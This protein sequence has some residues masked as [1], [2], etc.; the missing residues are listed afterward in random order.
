[1]SSRP[2][3]VLSLLLWLLPLAACA[4]SDA[5]FARNMAQIG[6]P[7]LADEAGSGNDLFHRLG[8]EPTNAR[9]HFENGRYLA[10]RG[11][12]GDLEMAR[13]AFA[14]ASRLA[15]DWWLPEIALAATEYRLGRYHLA[16]S[17]FIEAVERRGECGTL[18]YGFALAA[19]RA[20]YFGLAVNA[21]AAAKQAGPPIGRAEQRAAEFLSLA[22]ADGPDARPAAPLRERLRAPAPAEPST[23]SHNVA[24]DA[25]V[26]R[27]TR[28]SSSSN[29]INLLEALQLQFGATLVNLDYSS[30]SRQDPVK[31]VQRSLEVS[32]PTVTYA[33]N[34]A[35]ESRTTFSIEATPSVVAVA[36]QT[37]RFFEGANVLI[38]P[39]GDD[40]SPV[41]RD[42]GI[43]LQVTPS[44]IAE[45][46]V[47]LSASMELSTLAAQAV[48]GGGAQVLQTEKARA[49]ASAR[50]PFGRAM[51]LG[52]GA[53]MTS[54]DG[55][56]GVPGIRRIPGLGDLFGVDGASATRSDVLVL[57]AV[58]REFSSAP[59]SLVEEDAVS[60]RLFGLD[61][62]PVARLSR[63]PSEA[64]ALD[65]LERFWNDPNR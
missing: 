51:A 10:A 25:Y 1:M 46:H 34:I 3:R 19:F 2:A 61:P 9:L 11:R 22:L 15:P 58:R 36:G 42:I 20:G 35:S 33:L 31:R 63:L 6:F 13:V 65:F 56:A 29:G 32:I 14:N 53:R 30:E 50:I 64:P 18:C 21:L 55:E 5:Q 52:S 12:Y 40:T 17:A 60:R 49:E 28:D 37:S 48:G 45:G 8:A 44:D 26:I 24:I 4:S 59:A 27:Q 62:A 43:D 7:G 47:D 54:R 57:I 39:Q 16:L 41:E 23:A 38:V